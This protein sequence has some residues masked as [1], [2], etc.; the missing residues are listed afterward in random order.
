VEGLSFF[1]NVATLASGTLLAQ[2]LPI[3]FSP[4]LTRLYE[5]EAFGIFALYMAIVASITPAI[6]GKYEVAQV[7]PARKQDTLHLFV[8]AVYVTLLLVLLLLILF[9]LLHDEIIHTLNIEKLFGWI[10]WI[11]FSL[12]MLG[13]LNVFS[14]YSNRKKEYNILATSKI[15]Q[16]ISAVSVQFLFGIINAGFIGLL[17]A[18]ILSSTIATVYFL[19]KYI[20]DFTT[21]IFLLSSR[22]KVL[23]KEYAD[24]P[25]YNA[26]TGLLNGLSTSAPIF[27]LSFYYPESIVGYFA[28]VEKVAMAPLGFISVAVSQVN[29]KKVVD[30]V[31]HGQCIECYLYKVSGVL[32]LITFFPFVILTMYAPELF[33]FVFGEKW[34]MAGQF[35]QILIPAIALRFIVSTLSTTLGATKNNKIGAIWKIV[36]FISTI[37]VLSIYAPQGNI[38]VTLKAYVINEI[39][40]AILYYVAILYA[41]KNPNNAITVKTV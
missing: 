3:L 9:L 35:A 4:I 26:S 32:L 1:R 18:S 30:L 2:A 28:I 19:K 37:L 41:A 27:F 14:Y 5:P 36:Y 13:L 12:L 7:L 21:K 10:L 33:S 29:L 15:V 17:I 11:P 22:K 24:F 16:S 39:V 25:V 38:D 34:F 31:N 8:I 6:S 23:L 40:L 20:H